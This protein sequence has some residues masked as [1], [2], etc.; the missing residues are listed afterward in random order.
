MRRWRC[1]CCAIRRSLQ[2]C[3]WSGKIAARRCS[4]SVDGTLG[5][6]GCRIGPYRISRQRR[7]DPL[8]RHC[9][10]LDQG[11]LVLRRSAQRG[12]IAL[13]LLRLSLC[14]ARRRTDGCAKPFSKGLPP[15]DWIGTEPPR[16]SRAVRDHSGRE[17]SRRWERAPAPHAI[18]DQ[19]GRRVGDLSPDWR[20]SSPIQRN[21]CA[22]V[23]GGG[24][25]FPPCSGFFSPRRVF[26]A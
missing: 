16:A 23:L 13:E 15:T 21:S 8:R 25:I 1:R 14:T 9:L 22:T 6:A 10:Q 26:S 12:G 2:P 5:S 19:D 20:I 24:A 18:D 4:C 7:C 3:A 11:G 17:R